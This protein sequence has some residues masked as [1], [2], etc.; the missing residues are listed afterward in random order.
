MSFGLERFLGPLGS[1]WMHACL[2]FA[3]LFLISSSPLRADDKALAAA[4][5]SFNQAHPEIAHAWDQ[6]VGLALQSLRPDQFPFPSPEEIQRLAENYSKEIDVIFLRDYRDEGRARFF[7]DV[8]QRGFRKSYYLANGT[9]VLFKTAQIGTNGSAQSIIKMSFKGLD[10][11]LLIR[12]LP[13]LV[14][15]GSLSGDHPQ[16]FRYA[17]RIA[18]ETNKIVIDVE[19]EAETGRLQPKQ[20]VIAPDLW[21]FSR[22]K[23]YFANA[24]QAPRWSTV[25]HPLFA[26]SILVQ[27]MTLTGS[28]LIANQLSESPTN[29]QII[30]AAVGVRSAY[31]ILYA[32]FRDFCDR[33]VKVP[34]KE[35]TALSP[36]ES[37]GKALVLEMSRRAALALPAHLAVIVAVDVFMKKDPQVQ[38]PKFW[39]YIFSVGFFFSTFEKFSSTIQGVLVRSLE[40]RRVVEGNFRA[41]HVLR[42]LRWKGLPR[43][44]PPEGFIGLVSSVPNTIGVPFNPRYLVPHNFLRA[45]DWSVFTEI[46]SDPQVAAGK[47]GMHKIF[48]LHESLAIFRNIFMSAGA[49]IDLI[50]GVPVA[51]PTLGVISLYFLQRGAFGVEQWEDEALAAHE[52]DEAVSAQKQRELLENM[53]MLSR[54]TQAGLTERRLRFYQAELQEIEELSQPPREQTDFFR[55]QINHLQARLAWLKRR[56][57]IIPGLK[58]VSDDFKLG[59][60]LGLQKM[61]FR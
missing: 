3:V 25:T 14:N 18:H 42:N 35:E 8:R 60:R 7:Q 55:E 51:L 16:L 29:W 58:D 15:F 37:S 43:L 22:L 52:W 44:D 5:Q 32:A 6:S 39:I 10:G 50:T 38:D 21:T 48:L 45:V 9:R 2:I 34:P 40:E 23:G 33:L 54:K 28:F 26:T 56:E 61:G 19:H 4:V 20:V 12:N 57:W 46:D 53:S 30:A 24:K 1:V 47:K 31:N 41:L 13:N 49:T 27:G 17:R 36:S 11:V 59:C